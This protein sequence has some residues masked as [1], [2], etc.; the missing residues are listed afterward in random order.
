M[1]NS[2]YCRRIAQP[3]LHIEE[4]GYSITAL[5]LPVS[6]K[7]VNFLSLNDL[8]VVDTRIKEPPPFSKEKI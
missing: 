5:K 1:L 8:F 6:L 4:K 2:R 3:I 7:Y